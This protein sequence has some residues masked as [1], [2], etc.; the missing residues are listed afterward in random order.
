MIACFFGYIG[1]VASM[2]LEDR[3]TIN[4]DW[5]TTICLP[6]VINELRRTN[7]NRYIIFHHDNASCHTTRQTIDFLSSNNVGLM[8]YCPYLPDLSPNDFFLFPNIKNKMLFEE[9]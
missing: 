5:Y 4:I 8:I 1:H 3:K 6:E 9:W 2:A 7:R